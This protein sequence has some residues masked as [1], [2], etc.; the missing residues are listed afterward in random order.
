MPLLDKE[1]IITYSQ[2]FENMR[3]MNTL[4]DESEKIINEFGM[5]STTPLESKE[6]FNSVL[7][8]LDIKNPKFWIKF[9]TIAT[10]FQSQ[11]MLTRDRSFCN[12]RLTS[13][14]KEKYDLIE[15]KM[16]ARFG[17]NSIFGGEKRLTIPEIIFNSLLILFNEE[18]K[19]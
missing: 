5:A 7:N 3:V 15:S 12:I 4:L 14:N 13:Q 18:V 16:I 8:S 2:I 17:N 11:S 6:I 1:K 19:E 9:Q 10:L